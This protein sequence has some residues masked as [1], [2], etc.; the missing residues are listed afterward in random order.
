[1]SPGSLPRR[2]DLRTLRRRR[3]RGSVRARDKKNFVSRSVVFTY[4]HLYRNRIRR[5]IIYIYI[6]TRGVRTI[7]IFA[8]SSSSPLSSWPVQGFVNETVPYRCQTIRF[9]FKTVSIFFPT[10]RYRI[11]S[12]PGPRRSFEYNYTRALVDSG[13]NNI[14]Y[15]CRSWKAY[16]DGGGRA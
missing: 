2:K 5:L 1:M 3:G 15:Y 10:A 14:Y 16:G 12:T 13:A 9:I 6:Y 4:S 8:R 7:Y 11:P